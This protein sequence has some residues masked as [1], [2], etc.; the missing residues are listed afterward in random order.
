MTI[1]FLLAAAAAV[2]GVHAADWKPEKSIELV[3]GSAAG[4]PLDAT[5]RIVQRYAE[6]KNIGVPVTVQNRTGGAQAIA[7][8]YVS[9]R[10][11]DGHT[12]AM[13][14]PNL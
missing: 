1:V 8:T 11:G 6:Q 5:A 12:L 2:S 9:Q 10:T 14:L 7:M 4:G 13:V 3:V